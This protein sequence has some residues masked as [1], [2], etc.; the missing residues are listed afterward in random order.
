MHHPKDHSLF[1]RLG[2]QGIHLTSSC[3]IQAMNQLYPRSLEVG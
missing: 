1:G 3:V 2:S